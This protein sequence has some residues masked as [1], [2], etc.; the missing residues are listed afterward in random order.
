LSK[1][2]IFGVVSTFITLP[3]LALI[4]VLSGCGASNE[5]K[6]ADIVY[7]NEDLLI[8]IATYRNTSSSYPLETTI[9]YDRETKVEYIMIRQTSGYCGLSPRYDENGNLM[10]YTE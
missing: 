10:F 7:D 5:G 9:V 8:P 2:R 3:L 4:I 6:T 1:G